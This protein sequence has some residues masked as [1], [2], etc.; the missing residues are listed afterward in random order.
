MIIDKVIFLENLRLTQSYCEQSSPDNSKSIARALRRLNLNF[1]QNQIF[2]FDWNEEFKIELVNWNFEI[3]DDNFQIIRELFEQQLRQK[4]QEQKVDTNKI[5]KG[6]IIVSEFEST[7]VDGASEINS[8]GLIDIYDLPPIDTW[9]YMTKSNNSLNLFAW[10]PER[11][12]EEANC[13][14]EVNCMEI[15]FWLRSRNEDIFYDIEK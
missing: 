1:K 12:K 2:N 13:A 10:I 8:K 9:F 11:Y 7:V 6:D 3:F 5:F 14:I 15:L 4:K